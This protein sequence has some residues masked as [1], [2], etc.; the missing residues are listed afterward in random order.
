MDLTKQVLFW[1][2]GASE[3]LEVASRLVAEGRTRHG[4]FFLHLAFEKELKGL[5]VERLRQPA[6]KTH[7]LARLAQE[8]NLALSQEHVDILSEINV[9][10]LEGRYP[11]YWAEP[12]TV[13]AA[14]VL[15]SRA[16]EVLRCLRQN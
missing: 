16:K 15:L 12:L 6:P 10:C 3:D 7:N 9:H 2:L 4:L 5:Y 14:A 1:R 11:D 13:A 8:A